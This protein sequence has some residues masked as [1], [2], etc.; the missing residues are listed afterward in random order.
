VLDLHPVGQRIAIG[1]EGERLVERS[2]G[3]AGPAL[4]D[5]DLRSQSRQSCPDIEG[6]LVGRLPKVV[7]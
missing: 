6:P 3:L 1:E 5:L 7:K 2:L 4:G